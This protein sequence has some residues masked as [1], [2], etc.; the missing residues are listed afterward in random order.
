MLAATLRGRTE[1]EVWLQEHPDL[2]ALGDAPPPT[3]EDEKA[4]EQAAAGDKYTAL[5]KAIWLW[6]RRSAEEQGQPPYMIMS[7][8]LILRIA[9]RRPQTLEELAELPGMGAQRL[10]HYGPTLLDLIHLNPVH[11]GDDEL[12]TAQ[13]EAP[14]TRYAPPQTV[15]PQLERRLFMKLQEIRQKQAVTEGTKPYLVASNTLLKAIASTAPATAE[16]LDAL[17]GFRTSGLASNAGKIVAAIEEV[18][19]L[20]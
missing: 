2:A 19:A 1:A 7:N 18:R 5:Q 20:K 4:E 3:P 10:E 17:P 16:A 14:A 15:S 11:P 13:R 12:M 6:R 9:E 8:D